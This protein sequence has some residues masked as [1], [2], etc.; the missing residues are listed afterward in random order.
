M[1]NKLMPKLLLFAA[2]LLTTLVS[3]E[4]CSSCNKKRTTAMIPNDAG[5]VVLINMDDIWDKG[6]FKHIDQL[7]FIKN[8]RSDIKKE[9]PEIAKIVDDLLDDPKSCGLNLKGD[10]FFFMSKDMKD[11]CLGCQ[12]KSSSKFK[13]FLENL[14]NKFDVDIDISEESDYNLALIERFAICWN[15]SK[16]YGFSSE[17]RKDA[18]EQAKNL[19][20]LKKDNSMAQNEHFKDFI[21]NAGDIGVFLNYEN[22]KKVPKIGRDFKEIKKQF[23]PIEDASCYVSLSFEKDEIKVQGKTLGFC[24]DENSLKFI[25]KYID[26]NINIG[27]LR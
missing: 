8:M 17:S 27:D 15:G 16:A 7:G 10:V 21:K 19:M 25:L 14:N 3:F 9:D 5:L 6:D 1:K 2:L 18:E 4:S 20:S 23:K 11:G 26:E 13:K 24:K 22:I 12:V